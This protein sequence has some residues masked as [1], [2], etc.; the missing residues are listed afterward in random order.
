MAI[1]K[2]TEELLSHGNRNG[3]RIALNII[4]YA[5]KAINTYGA[6][7]KTVRIN[8]ER[9]I[10]GHLKHELSKIQNIYVV[11]AGKGTIGIA[12]ALEQILGSRIK[13]GIIIEKRGQ[14][15]K[16]KTIKVVEGGHPIPDEAGLARARPLQL[17]CVS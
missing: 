17:K 9:I 3:R 10:I 11:G 2:N 14:G 12:E 1:I 5:L 8:D 16:L 4:E 7:R 15:R 6:V 13:R